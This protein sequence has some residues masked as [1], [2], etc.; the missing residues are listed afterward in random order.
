MEEVKKVIRGEPIRGI[1]QVINEDISRLS[2]PAGASEV[3]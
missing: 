1:E 3:N 2:A